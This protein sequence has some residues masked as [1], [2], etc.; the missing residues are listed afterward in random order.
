M[1]SFVTMEL[2]AALATHLFPENNRM[3][4]G[5]KSKAA[6]REKWCEQL[7]V[8]KCGCIY[9][10]FLFLQKNYILEVVSSFFGGCCTSNKIML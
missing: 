4:G 7:E 2:D 6:A 8:G 1:G 9:E 10:R 5:V 3:S